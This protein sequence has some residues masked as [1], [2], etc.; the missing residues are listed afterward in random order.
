M[1]ALVVP[2]MWLGLSGDVTKQIF[3][4]NLVY[5]EEHGKFGVRAATKTWWSI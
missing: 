1:F 4:D 3:S 2:L 5:L